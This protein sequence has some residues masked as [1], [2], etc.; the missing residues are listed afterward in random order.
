MSGSTHTPP[1]H[2]PARTQVH[3]QSARNQKTTGPIRNRIPTLFVQQIK[4]A[5]DLAS[6]NPLSDPPQAEA[7]T[8]EERKREHTPSVWQRQASLSFLC[9]CVT[10][11]VVAA[12]SVQAS[13]SS[14]SPLESGGIAHLYVL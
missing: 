2:Q 14:S 11:S 7:D 9:V 4:A 6:G 10:V 13:L 3:R 12:E 1:W 5:T 8:T